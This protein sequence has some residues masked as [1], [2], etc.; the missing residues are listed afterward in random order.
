M[1]LE[2]LSAVQIMSRRWAAAHQSERVPE[3]RA[4]EEAYSTSHAMGTGP[5]RLTKREPGVRTEVQRNP[6]WWGRS[7]G[8]VQALVFLPIANDA[9][10]TAALLSGDADFTQE[11]PTQDLERL[12]RESALR[13]LEGPENRLVFLGMDQARDELLHSNVKGRNPFKDVRV[14]EAFARAIDADA[15]KSVIM[16]GRA[17]PTGCMS[18]NPQ[19]CLAPELRAR[20]PADPARARKLLAEAGYPDG[21][22]VRFDCPN[23]RY[24]NDQ[25]LCVAM[26]GMLARVG[27]TQRPHRQAD[28]RARNVHDDR[29]LGAPGAGGRKVKP[30]PM[31]LALGAL[32]LAAMAGAAMAD[33][34]IAGCQLFPG[35]SIFYQRIDDTARFPR[36]PDSYRWLASIGTR[37]RLFTD[38]GHDTARGIPY[39]VVD[40]TS[41]TTNWPLLSFDILDE[42]A[43][44]VAGVGVPHES[45]CARVEPA[46]DAAKPTVRIERPCSAMPPDQQRFPFPHPAVAKAENARCKAVGRC[47]DRHILVVEHGACRLWESYFSY[48]VDGHWKAYSTAAWDLA[49]DAIRPPRWTSSDAAGLPIVPLLARPDEASGTAMSHALRVTFRGDV[50]DRRAVWPASHVA[51]KHLPGGIPFGAM[52]RLRA[53]VKI[54]PHW[55][56]QA[57]NLATA[58]QRHGLIVADIGDDLWVTGEPG[59][60]WNA[61]TQSQLRS[62]RLDQFEFVDIG[63]ITGDARFDAGSYRAAW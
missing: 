23:D 30:R 39:N 61:A 34:M 1:L 32:S 25:A 10:R 31:R 24:I 9:T 62:L 8:N 50:M 13:L 14:R 52:L 44:P 15:L 54:P 37:T 46:S 51:G 5:Y 57:R 11:A 36:H 16:R 12:A 45:D 26:V 20:A 60:Q 21:F 29:A 33:G 58:M 55:T 7:E 47:G 4:K 3:Y 19:T 42:R 35:S 17:E 53:D 6:R 18:M 63:S 28:R 22:E 27:V 2:H 48:R 49:S 40:G 43:G 41:K 56:R 38:W 59:P